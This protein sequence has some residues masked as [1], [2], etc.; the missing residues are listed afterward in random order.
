M[1]L[2]YYEETTR[3]IDLAGIWLEG[4]VSGLDEL[5]RTL[6]TSPAGMKYNDLLPWLPAGPGKVT[7]IPAIPHAGPSSLRG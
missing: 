6:R 7:A 2:E 5:Q 4:R 3:W 1:G